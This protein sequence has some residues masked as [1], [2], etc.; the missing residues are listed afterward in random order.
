MGTPPSNVTLALLVA[1][2]VVAG[3]L[4]LRLAPRGRVAVV[5]L[6]AALGPVVGGA[7]TFAFC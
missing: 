3:L 5:A 6:V 7:L 4:L 2:G 1:A